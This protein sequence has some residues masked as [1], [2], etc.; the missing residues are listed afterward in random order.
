M[1]A[2]V[3][4]W[5]G[6]DLLEDAGGARF[7]GT[8]MGAGVQVEKQVDGKWAAL[9]NAFNAQ[10]Q[11]MSTSKDQDAGPLEALGQVDKKLN[12]LRDFLLYSE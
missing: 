1:A 4:K 10:W 9:V 12:A 11:G 3:I 5:R 2:R 6:I 7:R 8:G